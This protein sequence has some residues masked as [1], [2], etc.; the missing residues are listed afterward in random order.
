MFPWYVPPPSHTSI[1]V[2]SPGNVHI[3]PPN[4]T[5]S[6]F[7]VSNNVLRSTTPTPSPIFTLLRSSQKRRPERFPI[8]EVVYPGKPT[9]SHEIQC[10]SCALRGNCMTYLDSNSNRIV[11]A[12]SPRTLSL[13]DT[14]EKKVKTRSTSES[15][16][17]IASNITSNTFVSRHKS[18]IDIHNF[19]NDTKINLNVLSKHLVPS[20]FEIS[21]LKADSS[22]I[23]LWDI[24]AN[25]SRTSSLKSSQQHFLLSHTY[26]IH[27]RMLCLTT[28]SSTILTLDLRSGRFDRIYE[29]S[30]LHLGPI[31]SHPFNP[32]Q[33]VTSGLNEILVLDSRYRRVPLLRWNHGMKDAPPEVLTIAPIR[34]GD[35]DTMI[36]ASSLS[37]RTAIKSKET[38]I[39]VRS[40][41]MTSASHRTMYGDRSIFVARYRSGLETKIPSPFVGHG[42]SAVRK[43]FSL[44]CVVV[45]SRST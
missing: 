8:Q 15:I 18:Y 25:K 22:T 2:G 24:N 17:Q 28:K 43:H 27:P 38:C 36:C 19:E 13:W 41:T 34:G 1:R 31:K 26:A 21:V 9:I 6:S 12:S 30:N 16:L 20:P 3:I 29:S 44:P 35:G 14:S 39:T 23:L 4:S 40:Q 7:Q 42:R 32:F 5:S 10:A 45:D 11:F 33:I 37:L